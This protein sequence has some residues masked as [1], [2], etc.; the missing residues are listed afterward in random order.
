MAIADEVLAQVS[1]LLVRLNKTEKR[2]SI[3]GAF[4]K[5]PIVVTVVGSV[6]I[7][8][9]SNFVTKE[10]QLR[11]KQS[12]A[13][14]TLESEVPQEL[15]STTHL[16][17]ISSVLES[18][19]CSSQPNKKL[20]SPLVFGLTGKSCREAEAEYLKYY[21]ISLQHPP[22]SSLARI[23]ALFSSPAVDEGA[24]KLGA[25][26]GL[27][28]VTADDNCI[29]HVANQ[30][31]GAYEE[32]VD[33]TIQ[34]IDGDKVRDTPAIF[35]LANLAKQCKTEDLCRVPAISKDPTV[36]VACT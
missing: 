14:A 2:G 3:I 28:S 25:L 29:V 5:H 9:G 21:T 22:G 15:A 35:N 27:L 1:E 31:G 20:K 30:A 6:L 19:G 16:A 8:Y 32:L 18:E 23:R 33:L 26:L 4:L 7:T 13:V 34:E 17:M 24:K 10:F 12:D 11:D 36:K